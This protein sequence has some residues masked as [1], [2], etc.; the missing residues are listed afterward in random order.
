MWNFPGSP[1]VKSLPSNEGSWRGSGG[2][3]NPWWRSQDPTRLA[4]KHTH[5]KKKKKKK[6]KQYC[7][8]SIL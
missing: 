8:K 7:N 4:A 5:T 1:V 2:E 3:F 6:Q